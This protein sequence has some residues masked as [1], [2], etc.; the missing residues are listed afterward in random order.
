[1]LPLYGKHLTTISNLKEDTNR[2]TTLEL[3][4]K[5]PKP[6]F[7]GRNQPRS[8]LLRPRLACQINFYQDRVIFSQNGRDFCFQIDPQSEKVLQKLFLMM[9]GTKSLSEL[10]Q[11]FSPHNPKV[12]NAI[13]R[14]LEEQGLIDDA[15]ELKLY[16]GSNF[17][18]ELMDLATQLL[19]KSVA[20]NPFWKS[21]YSTE[22]ELP[23]NVLYG[24]ALENYQFFS[25]Q[26]CFDSPVLSFQSSPKVQRLLNECYCQAYGRKEFL[27]E[28]LNAI[29]I[30]QEELADTIPLPE[31]MAMGNALAYWANWEPLFFLSNR[32]W[33]AE[34]TLKN[35]T[36][37]LTA[38]KR[39]KLNSC[40]ID[41]IRRLVN[42]KLKRQPE[43]LTHRVF[44]EIPH[45]DRETRQRF[46]GQ[47]Y[48]FM[49]LYDNFSRGIWTYYKGANYLLR[50]VSA[51]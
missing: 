23:I 9:D 21:I 44:Q 26:C 29:G 3:E 22:S 48:L 1:M 8:Q 24:F 18:V 16:S 28:A 43:N 41:S 40:F 11:T 4:P 39:V 50:R 27:L 17:L 25:Q 45:L 12:I 42:T 35:F 49:E 51:I 33:L 20:E 36:S 30:S 37:Y 19:D 14:P 7:L 31:T 2:N 13:V 38:C 32:G 46:R 5:L 6:G 34:Q 47:I 10:Q 15:A